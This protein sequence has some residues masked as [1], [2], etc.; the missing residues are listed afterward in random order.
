MRVNRL[1][2]NPVHGSNPHRRQHEVIFDGEDPTAMIDHQRM[3][4][5][6]IAARGDIRAMFDVR[7]AVRE[8]LLAPG[9]VTE[10][11]V[12]R[13][14]EESGRGWVI[15]DGGRVVAF[16]IGD[17]G[18]RSIWA[19]FV[20]PEYE[21]RGHGRLLH[22]TM[23]AWLGSSSPRPIWLT[24]MPGTRADRFY[25]LL[26]WQAAGPAEDGQIRMELT[27]AAC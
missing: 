15:E 27:P 18:N 8:N 19:L 11:D 14:I 10:E 4:A 24:T 23:V 20:L 12:Q 22:D 5:M 26:G 7:L 25:R 16:G 21:G 2:A 17:A 3:S 6:R 13:A 1:A 9:E